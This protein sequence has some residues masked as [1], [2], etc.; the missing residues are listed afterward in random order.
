MTIQCGKYPFSL[1]VSSSG[2]KN[3][4]LVV[5]SFPHQVPFPLLSLLYKADMQRN[6]PGVITGTHCLD[7]TQKCVNFSGNDEKYEFKI[8]HQV[9]Q[10]SPRDWWHCHTEV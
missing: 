8:E 2:V 10:T 7:D 4:L 6:M 5:L 9:I 1:I 3:F